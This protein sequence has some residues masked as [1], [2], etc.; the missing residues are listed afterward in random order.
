MTQVT[1]DAPPPG[2]TYGIGGAQ[3]VMK[4]S[5]F[6]YMRVKATERARFHSLSSGGDP[7]F[8][9]CRFHEFGTFEEKNQRSYVCLHWL[10]QG[11]EECKYC[12]EG[13]Q[14]RSNRFALWVWCYEI[15]HAT[16]NPAQD[17]EPWAQ[18]KVGAKPADGQ[19]DNRRTLFKEE[20]NRPMLLELK[21]G[22]K[23]QPW[24]RQ[25]VTE[26]TTHGT[27]QKY[28]YELWHQLNTETNPSFPHNYVLL[29]AKE[30]P[31]PEEVLGHADVKNLPSV[32]DVFRG[33][34]N[35]AQKT[36]TEEVLGTDSVNGAAA[37]AAEEEAIED[38]PAAVPVDGA[39]TGDDL[40]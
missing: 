30:A 38:L 31:V 37:P 3:E 15:F 2:K 25:F 27:L 14:P 9:A 20:I 19:P 23:G 21:G 4:T 34:L 17:G 12:A 7:L 16:D 5:R 13:D 10:T 8:Q 36:A 6:P 35:F 11:N 40:I 24:Y 26:Y 39:A 32:E 18:V 29:Q 22:G 33:S 28:L 1:E